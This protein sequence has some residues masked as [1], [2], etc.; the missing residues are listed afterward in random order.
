VAHGTKGS[1]CQ[2]QRVKSTFTDISI[3]VELASTCFR[4]FELATRWVGWELDF[5]T[6]CDGSELALGTEDFHNDDR[7]VKIISQIYLYFPKFTLRPAL[8]KCG[9]YFFNFD[10]Y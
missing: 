7:C 10:L 1:F 3:V 6:R 8:L 4:E 2:I 9:L 5:L